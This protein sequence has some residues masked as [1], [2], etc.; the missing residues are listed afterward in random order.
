MAALAVICL[1][2]A[3][4]E[5]ETTLI[6]AGGDRAIAAAD[7]IASLFERSTAQSL[8]SMRLVA[9]DPGIREYVRNP[10]DGA[11]GAVRAHLG[12][13]AP[14][15]VRRI[16]LWDTTG[17]RLLEVITPASDPVSALVKLPPQGSR[18]FA[19]GVGPLHLVDDVAF[20]DL[21]VE[22]PSLPTA[23][24]QTISPAPLGFLLIRG[25]LTVNPPGALSRLAGRD[26]V[27]SVG[28]QTGGLWTDL[29][30]LVPMPP[31]DLTRRGVTEYPGAGGEWRLGAV[32]PVRGTVSA[33]WV[34]FPRSTVVASAEAFLFRMAGI[35]LALLAMTTVLVTVMSRRIT[36]PLYDVAEAAD[37]I[38]A[39]DFARRT[40]TSRSDEIGRVSRAFNAMTDHVVAVQQRLADDARALGQ[41]DARKSAVMAGALDCIVSM[42]HLGNIVE[43]NPAAERTFGHS[44]EEAIGRS[45]ADLLI[46]EPM[47]EHHRQGLAR[48]LATGEGPVIGK[49]IEVSALR[50]D[51]SQCPVELAVVAIAYDGPP[52]FT[53]FL[54]DLTAQ[55]TAEAVRLR[56]L[57]IEEE[58]KQVQEANRLKGE[59]LA[60]MSHELRTPLNSIIGFAE[61]MHK[62]KV[63]PVSD[64]HAEYL[65]DIVTSSRHLLQLVND[66]LDLAKVES[67]KMDFR[68][69]RVDLSKLVA[70]V[71]S[72]LR[73]LAGSKR[74][75][76]DT[77]VA[78]DVTMVV[79]D[80]ARVKQ[81]L[82][83]YLS[84]AIK[85]TP[86]VGLVTVE[87]K[88]E[89]AAFFR[90]DVTD[91]GVGIAEEDLAKLFIEFQQLDA[92]LAKKYQGTGLGLALTRQ[93]AES[94][95]GH[96][97]VRSTAGVGS[98]FWVVLPR[99]MTPTSRGAPAVAPKAFDNGSG[100]V[101]TVLIVD[102]DATALKL[103]DANLREAGFRVLC[104]D[105]AEG[106]LS[107]ASI[108][109]PAAVIV[110][111]LMPRM[112]GF[113]FV[114]R[115][116]Q[117]K[118]SADVPVVAWTVKD[119]NADERDRLE[120]LA[121]EVVLKRDGGVT[122]LLTALR[123]LLS[124]SPAGPAD[125]ERA[126]LVSRQPEAA[127]RLQLED[128]SACRG[129]TSGE[130]ISH[131][132]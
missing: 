78:P 92:G 27:V 20:S 81:I 29:S 26:A 7:Q 111:L 109:R 101:P 72:I 32:A 31:G 9:S 90:I 46:P 107:M 39:G 18:P 82:Y 79:V 118:S 125:G 129:E 95:G 12:T 3:Y 106:A 54:R 37:A 40:A 114:E 110:D 49:R 2:A 98:T 61:L 10:S 80:P 113:E 35:T 74:I 45:L 67:G 24:G 128:R 25:T 5:V 16:E 94:Q 120:R 63:G 42:D 70:E 44:R 65:G 36:T 84:N 68:P 6:R 93:L 99:V 88:P 91:T 58:N 115:F 87:I 11:R 43:F 13:L 71:R 124:I 104:A 66:V 89:G 116:R 47:R 131:G 55:R 97:G 15:A 28:N 83:N 60:N 86:D 8:S 76:I 62:G 19:A 96:V 57:Q 53:G 103:A 130:G 21:V 34:D 105:S 112:D 48:Y 64:T 41:S 51:G 127:D 117:D 85:F 1:W 33:V 100:T 23:V 14:T 50:K 132:R 122:T 22:V 38:A 77:S 73:E 123:R 59:F 121:A 75:R 126:L 69:E 119:L 52:M 102:D 108:H 17:S 56:S 30:K 4:R